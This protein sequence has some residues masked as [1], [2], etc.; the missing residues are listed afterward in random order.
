MGMSTFYHTFRMLGQGDH[1]FKASQSYMETLTQ[2]K[3][4]M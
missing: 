3:T 1:K 4:G 2:K